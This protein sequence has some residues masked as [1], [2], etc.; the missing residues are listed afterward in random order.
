M[1][2]DYVQS[3]RDNAGDIHLYLLVARDARTSC[4]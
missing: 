2:T 4:C 3:S 1:C